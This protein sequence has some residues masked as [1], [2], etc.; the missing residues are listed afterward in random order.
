MTQPNH[1]V[2][3]A[4]VARLSGVSSATASRAINGRSGVASKVRER[5]LAIAESLDYQPNSAARQ[6]AGGR[7]GT[8]GFALPSRGLDRGSY[9]SLLVQGLSQALERREL[10]MMVWTTDGARSQT[11]SEMADR[12]QLDGMIIACPTMTESWVVE[13]LED[14]RPAVLLDSVGPGLPAHAIYTGNYNGAKAAMMHLIEGGRKRIAHL[15]GLANRYDSR[16]RKDAYLTVCKTHGFSTDG[17]I[18][19]GGYT[20]HGAHHGMRQLLPLKPDAVFA[21]DDSM[22]FGAIQAI[23]DAGLRVPEDIA[24][25]GYNNTAEADQTQLSSVTHDRAEIAEAGVALLEQ[26]IGNPDMEPQTIEISNQ[27][28]VRDS[29]RPKTAS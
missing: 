24:V 16:D 25:V 11:I 15:S 6:L 26:V 3:L 17:L 1:V 23:T 4:E 22:A 28:I 9:G 8:I 13:L 7:S 19:E 5:V 18:A 27:L 20:R 14:R 29:S 12:H 10:S 21:A 2:T